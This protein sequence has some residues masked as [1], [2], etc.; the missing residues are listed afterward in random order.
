LWRSVLGRED[1]LVVVRW[2]EIWS[3][4]A[5]GVPVAPC[6]VEEDAEGNDS[7]GRPD[8]GSGV[9]RVCDEAGSFCEKL[10]G[11]SSTRRGIVTGEERIMQSI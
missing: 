10:E 3:S 1:C 11:A 5:I 4:R 6:K 9:G 7:V 2:A 8:I